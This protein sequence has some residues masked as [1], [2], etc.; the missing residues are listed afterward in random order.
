MADR[1]LRIIKGLDDEEDRIDYRE[2]DTI[3]RHQFF[4]SLTRQTGRDMQECEWQRMRNLAALLTIP[5]DMRN[6]ARM[7]DPMS[8]N[9]DWQPHTAIAHHALGI[10]RRYKNPVQV[11]IN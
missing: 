11:Q 5:K 4:D 1:I 7:V 6:M 3:C 2:R 9:G 10:L 8:N